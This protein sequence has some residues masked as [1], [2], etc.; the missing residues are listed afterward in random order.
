MSISSI[1]GAGSDLSQIM[2]S[3]LSRIQQSEDATSTD[4]S[5][6]ETFTTSSE[7]DSSATL[8]GSSTAS[9][10]DQIVGLLVMSQMSGSD[11]SSSTASDQSGTDPISQAFSSMDADGDG[12]LS[13]SEME[14]AIT[15]AGGT[16]EQADAV[17]S[18]LGGTSDTGISES[19]FTEAAMDGMPPPPPGGMPGSMST[20]DTSSSDDDDDDTSSDSTSAI[21]TNG[22][23]AIS[24]SELTEYLE[25]LQSQNQSDENQ[26]DENQ[27][28]KS[29]LDSLVKLAS[30][31]YGN[32]VSLFAQNSTSQLATA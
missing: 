12:T 30:Q 2:A 1:G 25:K 8:T 24:Q 20:E 22:D 16:A 32:A 3:L 11:P 19:A 21:D 5:S 27:S 10:S 28:A 29:T 9:L 18:A 23:G 26:S 6:T 4:S 15:D 17:Y 7:T 31:S 14:T 13:Q